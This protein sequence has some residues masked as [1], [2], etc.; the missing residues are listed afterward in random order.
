LRAD[1]AYLVE[2]LDAIDVTHDHVGDHDVEA[3]LLQPGQGLVRVLEGLHLVAGL[4][5]DPLQGLDGNV[6]VIEN[7]DLDFSFLLRHVAS[8]RLEIPVWPSPTSGAT[9]G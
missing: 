5:E 6:L 1:L 7:H 8:S 3:G 9:A 2:H 4:A